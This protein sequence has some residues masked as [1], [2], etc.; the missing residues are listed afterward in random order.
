MKR[1]NTLHHPSTNK[2]FLGN[3]S[4][5]LSFAVAKHS[6][7]RIEYCIAYYLICPKHDQTQ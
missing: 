3:L 4:S 1:D 6:G 5:C 7:F 2:I